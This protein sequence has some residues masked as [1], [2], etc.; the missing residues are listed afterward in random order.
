MVRANTSTVRGLPELK[1]VFRQLGEGLAG[2]VL[3][4]AAMDGAF[5]L[6]REIQPRAPVGETGAY[7]SSIHVEQGEVK[8]T[9]AEASVLTNHEAAFALEMGSGLQ[10]ETGP[11]EKY[12]IE[13]DEKKALF[14]PGAAHPM[15][16]VMHPGID[17]QPHWRPG[18]EAGKDKATT[19]VGQSISRDITR[20]VGIGK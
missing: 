6:Q 11:K 8:S 9:S 7:R 10:A 20:I 19:A 3:G 1:A 17:A 12:A 4:A 18:F 14:W 15:F 13:P 5:V 16:R 2:Q